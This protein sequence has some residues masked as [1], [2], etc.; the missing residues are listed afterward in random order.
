M[1]DICDTSLHI[2][3]GLPAG[4]HGLRYL[5]SAL[6][7]I[8]EERGLSHTVMCQTLIRPSPPV[9]RIRPRFSSFPATL[10]AVTPGTSTCAQLMEYIGRSW[11]PSITH[12]SSHLLSTP[13]PESDFPLMLTRPAKG[14]EETIAIGWG[15]GRRRKMRIVRSSDAEARRAPSGEKAMDQT[16]ERWLDSVWKGY[17]SSCGSSA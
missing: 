1:L 9:L 13:A 12:A 14:L 2:E 8:I 16:V 7:R 6:A 4:R 10:S 3:V 11:A 5:R 17:Q 15:R